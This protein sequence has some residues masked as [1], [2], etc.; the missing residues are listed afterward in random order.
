MRQVPHIP[1]PQVVNTIRRYL[2]AGY[3]VELLSPRANGGTSF[4][5]ELLTELRSSNQLTCFLPDIV[6][7]EPL[8]GTLVSLLAERDQPIVADSVTSLE[9][10]V[11]MSRGF[12]GRP[13]VLVSDGAQAVTPLL[14]AAIAHYRRKS[15]LQLVVL[16]ESETSLVE[17]A[18]RAVTVNLPLLKVDEIGDAL[19]LLIDAPVDSTTLRRIYAKSGGLVKIACAMAEVATIE[20]RLK[21]LD[22]SW[23]A[24]D[25]LW[26]PGLA[27]MIRSKGLSLDDT[28][29]TALEE[30]ALA[31]LTSAENAIDLIG[32]DTLRRLVSRGVVAIEPSGANHW[33]TVTPPLLAEMLSRQS[34]IPA[35]TSKSS[36]RALSGLPGAATGLRPQRELRIGP[37]TPQLLR[38]LTE[39]RLK[40]LGETQAAWDA[41][42]SG[43]T[44][45]AYI[46][47]LVNEGASPEKV[48]TF[49][50][51]ASD[52]IKSREHRAW[53]RVWEARVRAYGMGDLERGIELLTAVDDLG[54]FHGLV[55]AARIRMQCD[56]GVIPPDAEQ[57]LGGA[58]RLPL[59]VQ[60]EMQWALVA[61]L[62]AKGHLTRAEQT[63]ALISSSD[64]NVFSVRV[65]AFSS[66]IALFQGDY[67]RASRLALSG[68]ERAADDLDPEMIRFYIFVIS[69]IVALRGQGVDVA[70]IRETLTGLGEKPLFPQVSYLGIYVCSIIIGKGTRAELTHLESELEQLNT[71]ESTMPGTSRAWAKAR[72]VAA[73]GATEQAADLCWDDALRLLARG[74]RLAAAFVG[75]QSLKH[76]FRKD[77]AAAVASWL[78]DID[79]EVLDAA[80]AAVIAADGEDARAMF[81]V[82]PRLVASG[83]I[84]S[85]VEGYRQLHAFPETRADATLSARAQ[86]DE[87]QFLA[88]LEHGGR[89]LLRPG[90]TMELL[91]PREAEVARLIAAGLTNRQIQ[92]E[93]VLSIRTVE[94]HRA[95]VMRKLGAKTRQETLEAIRAWMSAE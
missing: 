58:N 84:Q 55:D 89:D 22:G 27:P 56:L 62:I 65:Q 25:E 17:R 7:T 28:D 36:V 74:G 42:P 35:M 93:L 15:S 94:N 57:L 38:G 37:F 71:R 44:A 82:L 4:L 31:G 52:L 95:H 12:G 21:L 9:L 3:D 33:V 29:S 60:H 85:A 20:G 1:R 54:E 91:T 61:L 48:L 14:Q 80:L 40:V 46:S 11:H 53:I 88:S 24:V 18:S 45:L 34:V 51:Q 68:L 73:A 92:K 64:P 32:Q 90:T 23:V 83:Q 87:S 43:A 5:N 50:D 10:A 26:S 16:T 19:E 13:L 8:P 86:T 72:L 63:L 2:R 75:V 49:I 79:S 47:V 59:T 78:S 41:E 81:E 70:R 76:E 6:E 77:R 66:L 69:L 39:R 67:K 30:L